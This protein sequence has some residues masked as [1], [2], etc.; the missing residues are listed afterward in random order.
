MNK[1]KYNFIEVSIYCPLRG[2]PSPL[3]KN[4]TTKMDYKYPNTPKKRSITHNSKSSG[5]KVFFKDLTSGH[6]GLF[7]KLPGLLIVAIWAVKQI[8]SRT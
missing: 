3:T 1:V 7:C 2:Q 4:V 8:Y 5:S 6:I